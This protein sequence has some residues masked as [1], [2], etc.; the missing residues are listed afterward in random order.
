MSKKKTAIDKYFDFNVNKIKADI[1][2]ENIN[3]PETLIFLGKVPEVTYKSDK[4]DGK[5]R[6]YSHKLK[7]YGNL[8]IT[9][10]GKT[11]I[12]T[13]LSLNITKRGLTG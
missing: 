4:F 11:I 5:A 13:G 9:P 3:I 7:K 1:K 12:I 8:L 2:T 6:T 10:N